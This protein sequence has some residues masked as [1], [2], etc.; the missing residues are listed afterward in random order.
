MS[1]LP[2]SVPPRVYIATPSHDHKLHAGFAFS[3]YRLLAARVLPLQP[4]KVG[5]AGVARARNNQAAEFLKSKCDLFFAI[6]ADITFEP[7]YV[8][9][10]VAHGLPIVCG[11]YPLKQHKLA[12]CVNP[13]P[14]EK[15]DPATGLQKV[16]SS[17]TGFMCI[18]RAVFERMIEAHPELAYTEDLEES[19]GEVRYD[20]FSMGVDGP[21]SPQAR[22]ERIRE[23]LE[24]SPDPALTLQ[25]IRAVLTQ[26]HPPG[27]YLTE[28][29]YF[30][31]RARALG[32]PVY[33]DCTFHLKHE[34][35]ID[36][37]LAPVEMS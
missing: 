6:D 9:R 3:L 31:H 36:Y 14:G 2:S 8:Q 21:G 29:W 34:G 1:D 7:E 5:G 27:R 20:F 10:L 35:M 33:V 15:I 18:Q 13:L 28:D 22:L 19:R 24:L 37:P 12:W 25:E 32:I 16:A 30:C 4:S 17:G 23:L 26:P 11:L